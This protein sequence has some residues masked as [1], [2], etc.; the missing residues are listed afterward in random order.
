VIVFALLIFLGAEN[1]TEANVE[2]SGREWRKWQ[3]LRNKIIYIVFIDVLKRIDKLKFESCK[4]GY[5]CL[6]T[7]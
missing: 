3:I 2:K 1:V 4:L 7:K 6:L 5:V